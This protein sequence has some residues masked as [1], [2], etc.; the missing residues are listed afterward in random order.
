M[1]EAHTIDE[2]AL[3]ALREPGFVTIS[4][5]LQPL[6]VDM[7]FDDFGDVCN[8]VFKED[9]RGILRESF[10]YTLDDSETS[11]YYIKRTLPG[12]PNPVEPSR[13]PSLDKKIVMHFGPKTPEMVKLKAG[14]WMPGYFEGFLDDCSDAYS[15]LMRAH[16]LGAQLI[17]LSD[18]L[19]TP[20]NDPD[21]DRAHMRLL[22]YDPST[23]TDAAAGLHLDRSVST[24]AATEN[25]PGLHG[26]PVPNRLLHPINEAKRDA[27]IQEMLKRP[28]LQQPG[29]GKF[30]LGAGYE[31]LQELGIYVPYPDMPALLHGV[32]KQ[33]LSESDRTH[34]PST[35]NS[36]KEWRKSLILFVNPL[37]RYVQYSAP[38]PEA[39][40]MDY[41][42]AA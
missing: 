18:I 24:L 29:A 16:K 19:H 37:A 26:T 20:N 3:E 38:S 34:E 1:A 8:D 6:E 31:R 10:C 14:K 12:A 4:H 40:G 32:T 33:T 17:G 28:V 9:T 7:L 2:S 30:F 5:G 21:E 22:M 23:D 42:L 39:C 27:Y 25:K 35:L 36:Y 41:R 15:D 11:T 13:G